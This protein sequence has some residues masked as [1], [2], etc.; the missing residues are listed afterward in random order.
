MVTPNI[1]TFE[2]ASILIVIAYYLIMHFIHLSVPSINIPLF[3]TI[4]MP[5]SFGG[6]ILNFNANGEFQITDNYFAVFLVFGFQPAFILIA[7]LSRG[8]LKKYDFTKQTI[9]GGL[10]SAS[11]R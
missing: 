3:I 6:N 2:N 7:A 9:M 4:Y 11:A 5:I 1:Y 8:E 10:F